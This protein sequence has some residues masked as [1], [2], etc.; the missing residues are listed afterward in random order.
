VRRA[1]RAGWP[2][3]QVAHLAQAKAL[4]TAATDNRYRAY[5]TVSLLTGARTEELRALTWERVDPDGRPDTEPPVP[6]SIEVRRS[7][8]DHGDTKTRKSRRTLALP[9]RCVDAL[10]AHRTQQAEDRQA[11]GRDWQETGLVFASKLGTEL[12]A[13][14]VRRGF[15]AVIKRA[16]LDPAA[17]T[18]RELRHSFVSLLSDSGVSIED[19]A[20]LDG[21]HVDLP[22]PDGST[23]V[24]V[25]A[26]VTQSRLATRVAPIPRRIWSQ[27]P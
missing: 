13:H 22:R 15:R 14:N 6:P 2:A 27:T 16:G 19:I 1:D 21:V 12:D 9:R 5:I 26:Q 20:D 4:L 25:R 23:M 17:W 7:V 3:L 18:P 8:R 10:R 24:L 11:A